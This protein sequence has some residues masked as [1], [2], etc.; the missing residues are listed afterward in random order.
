MR[1]IK[2]EKV[3]IFGSFVVDLM[4][5]VPHIPVPGET[6]ASSSFKM[7][8]G[9]KALVKVIIETCLLTDD[10]KKMACVLSKS[11]GADYVKASTGF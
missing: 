4:A 9:G 10:E 1:K 5:R 3:T 7:G 6:L 2:N 8:A 11:S